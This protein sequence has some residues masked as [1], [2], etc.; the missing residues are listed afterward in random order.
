MPV[1]VVSYRL[2]LRGKN[3]GTHVMKTA[4]LGRE[5]QLEARSQFQSST[6]NAT[7][8]QRSRSH[9][10][11]RHSLRFREEVVERNEQRFLDVTF[12][13]RS[14]LVTASK[15]PRDSSSMPYLRD[16]RDPLSLLHELRGMAARPPQ[17]ADE[18]A[19][20]DATADGAT[21]AAADSATFPMLGK[22]VHAQLA[23]EVDVETGLG[24]KR[25]RAY[26]LHPGM[27]VVYVAVEAPHHIVKMSQR[28]PE[29]LLDVV[30]V[31]LG[32]EQALA[33]FGVEARTASTE[34][35]GQQKRRARRRRPRRGGRRG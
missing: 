3:V 15:G 8:T 7:V 33:Q 18:S 10:H 35:Q 2:A 29:G 28:L 24:V 19:P 26:L 32:S 12:D 20:E 4:V 17:T 22:D 30:L 11:L 9:A 34:G 14:G 27:S 5:V 21:D 16:Y 1:E 23:G 31:K 25:A 13:A 6:L